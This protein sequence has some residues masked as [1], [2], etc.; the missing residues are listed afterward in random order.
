MPPSAWE[1]RVWRW[2][3]WH[4]PD[5]V[6]PELNQLAWVDWRPG[7]GVVAVLRVGAVAMA[8]G[9]VRLQVQRQVRREVLLGEWKAA[10]AVAVVLVVLVLVVLELPAA[11]R[12]APSSRPG[13]GRHG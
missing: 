7:W 4:A 6:R 2:L 9:P 10:V 3:F 1:R 8:S 11:W 12:P 5:F 13:S